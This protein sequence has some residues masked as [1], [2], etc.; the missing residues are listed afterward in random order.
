MDTI[1]LGTYFGKI[2]Y[3][4]NLDLGVSNC[5]K[6]EGIVVGHPSKD[7]KISQFDRLTNPSRI[8]AFLD[9]T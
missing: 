3:G 1:F 6:R 7:L 2:V 4:A 8:N 9:L 5:L